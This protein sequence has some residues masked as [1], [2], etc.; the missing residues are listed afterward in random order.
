ML[1]FAFHGIIYMQKPIERLKR[2][3]EK[4]NLWIFILS[5]LKKQKKYGM[6]L[7]E[8]IKK[9]FGFLTGNVTTY[10]VLYLLEKGNYVESKKSGKFVLYKLTRKGRSELEK[11]KKV[12]RAYASRI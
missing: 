3:I 2:K 6:E 11:A 4:E 12:L 8:S 9:N 7:R 5:N 10:K 1:I